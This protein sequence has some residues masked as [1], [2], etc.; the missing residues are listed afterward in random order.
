MYFL[1]R[2]PRSLKELKV[3]FGNQSETGSH[4]VFLLFFGCSELNG[5]WLITS[6]LANQRAGKV[7]F[8]CV[9]YILLNQLQ[10]ENER[11]L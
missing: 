4:F 5:T 6:G 7:L 1:V 2:H 3:L 10:Y 11:A 8:T 9:V